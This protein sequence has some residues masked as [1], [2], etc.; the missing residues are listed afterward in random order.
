MRKVI[1]SAPML[2]EEGNFSMKFI[3]IEEAAEFAKDATNFVG[4]QTV[5]VLGIEPATSREV[6]TGF[7]QAL[8]LKVLGRLEFGVEYSAEEIMEIGVQ[9]ILIT[10]N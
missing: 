4:H 8:A 2:L 7:E 1:L 5:K 9:P 6:C 10:K 3:S